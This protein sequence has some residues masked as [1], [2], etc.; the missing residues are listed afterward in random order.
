MVRGLRICAGTIRPADS[1]MNA[2]DVVS[3]CSPQRDEVPAA[4]VSRLSLQEPNNA[5]RP[6]IVGNRP[7]RSLSARS[8]GLAS[9]FSK[10]VR[11]GNQK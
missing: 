9:P 5:R 2:R 3:S 1:S 6:E 10:S 8:G 4:P 7:T 11:C